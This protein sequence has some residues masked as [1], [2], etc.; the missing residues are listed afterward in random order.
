MGGT[1]FLLLTD[2]EELAQEVQAILGSE[3]FTEVQWRKLSG[4]KDTTRLGE[5]ELVLVEMSGK[6]EK[7]SGLARTLKDRFAPV[8]VPFVGLVTGGRAEAV[9]ALEAG[10]DE[11]VAMPEDR[12]ELGVRVRVMMRLRRQ[13]EE[14]AASNRRLLELSSRDELTGLYNRR[15]FFE[16]LALEF[17]CAIRYQQPLS[18]IMVDIDQFKPI[19]DNYGHLVGDALFKKAAALFRGIPRR[20]DVVAR[21]GGDEV[22]ILLPATRVDAAEVVAGRLCETMAQNQFRISGQDIEMTVSVGV[23]TMDPENPISPDELLRRADLAL[24]AVKRTGRNNVRVWSEAL[25]E[26]SRTWGRR[27][28]RGAGGLE[29]EVRDPA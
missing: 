12:A 17:E 18:C 21:Y 11:A 2:S 9:R 4:L 28:E 16:C 6:P 29:G 13:V 3:G 20:V 24:Y 22:V 27:D 10:L 26:E 14:L 25:A 19:N 15:H 8:F 7:T 5:P 1:G 23:A